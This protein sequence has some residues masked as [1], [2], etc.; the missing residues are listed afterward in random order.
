MKK[1]LKKEFK[2]SANPL[3][4]IFL[5]AAFMTFFPGYPILCSA[6][7]VS[8]GIFYTFQSAREGNDILYAALLP[9]KKGDVVKARFIFVVILEIIAFILMSVVTL[10]R[11]FLLSNAAPYVNNALMN[12]NFMSLGFSLV[13]FAA[14]N[15]FFVGGFWKDAHRIGIPFLSS[16]IATFIIIGIAETL[17]HIP[18]LE[19]LNTPFGMLK[20]QLPILFSSAIIYVVTTLISCRMSVSSF[21]RIDLTL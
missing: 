21:E 19:A 10:F 12:A 4:Y 6:F 2:F 7:F 8:M 9:V 14:F 15:S 5:V 16:C 17:H 20:I 13:V 1:L 3:S 18:G 11:M